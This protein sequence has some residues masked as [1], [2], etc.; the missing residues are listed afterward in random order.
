MPDLS[1]VKLRTGDPI[2]QTFY[3]DLYAVLCDMNLTGVII[4]PGYVYTSLIPIEDN[5]LNLGIPILRW[6]EVHSAKG[7]FGNSTTD[8]SAALDVNDDHFRIR[9]SKTP[10]SAGDTGKQGDICWDSS[11][12]YVCIATDTWKR[13]TISTWP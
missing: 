1:K 11:Y 4:P 3:D 8:P 10:A 9:S 13:A 5:I 12:V 7:V 6:K 2:T